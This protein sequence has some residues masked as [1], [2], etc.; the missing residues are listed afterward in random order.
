MFRC[1]ELQGKAHPAGTREPG[2][3]CRCHG[4]ICNPIFGF[5]VVHTGTGTAWTMEGTNLPGTATLIGY[6]FYWLSG[7]IMA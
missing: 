2:S 5:A 4:L 1:L 6:A 3:F 7:M